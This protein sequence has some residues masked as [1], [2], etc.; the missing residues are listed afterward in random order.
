MRDIKHGLKLNKQKAIIK[1][2]KREIGE[3]YDINEL[4]GQGGYGKVYKAM[5]KD[6]GIF[7]AVKCLKKKGLDQENMKS[8]MSEFDALR[9]LDHP[10]LVKL[11]EIYEDKDYIF[12]VQEYLSGLQLYDELCVREK[13][14]EEDARMVFKQALSAI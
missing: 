13:F 6:T 11:I 14:S 1:V 8:I 12:L 9:K 10:N 5:H 4:I 2:Q 7:R 3:V